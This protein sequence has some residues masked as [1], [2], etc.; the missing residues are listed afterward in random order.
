MTLVPPT[1]AAALAARYTIERELGR[2]GM[3]TVYLARD[4]KHDRPVALKLLSPDLAAVLG[5][6]RF[7]REIRMAARLQHPHILAVHDSGEAAGRLW[8]TMPFVDGESL[9]DRLRRERQLA[10][11]DAVR[12]GREA[13]LALD[14]AH[15]HGVVHRDIK[16]ENILLT[17]EGQVLIADFG[18]ARALQGEDETLTQTGLAVGTPTYMSPEQ[19]AG[20]RELDGRSDLY[21]L[22]CVVYEMLAGEPPHTGPSAQAILARRLT[23]P[24]RPLRSTRD[25]VPATVEAAVMRALAR[26]PA[27]RFPSTAEFARALETRDRV[28]PAGLGRRRLLVAAIAA[29]TVLAAGVTWLARHPA[30]P[31]STARA[32]IAIL[33]FAVR[34]NPALAYMGEG[35]VELL[36]TKLDGAGDLRAV[37][38]RALLSAVR[39]RS[40]ELAPDDGRAVARRFG[41]ERYVLGSVL[42]I[43]DSVRLSAGLY[44]AGGALQASAES[45]AREADIGRAVDE[46]A[47]L[48]LGRMSTT[49]ADRLESIGAVTTASFPALRAYLDGQQAF[50]AGQLDS[51]VAAFRRATELDT[52]FALA[53]YR[54]ATAATWNNQD[55]LWHEAMDRAVHHAKRLS[56]RDRALVEAQHSWRLGRLIESERRYHEIVSAYPDDQEAWFWLGDVRLHTNFL[57]GRGIAEAEPALRRALALDPRDWQARGHLEGLLRR[58]GRGAAA[59]SVDTPPD[60]T[61]PTFAFVRRDAPGA[62]GQREAIL[63]AAT[64][65]QLYILA[66]W[67]LQSGYDPATGLRIAT[68]L[69]EAGRPPPW[70][71]HGHLLLGCERL[72]G[73][74]WDAAD[75][76]FAA[77]ERLLPEDGLPYRAL[78]AV[79]SPVPVPDSTLRGLARRLRAW[80]PAPLRGH[81]DDKL[82]PTAAL[83][84]SRTLVRRFLIA[85]LDLRL[86]STKAAAEQAT[87]L[88]SIQDSDSAGSLAQDLAATINA[89]LAAGGNDADGVLRALET[90]RFIVFD[91]RFL[92]PLHSHGAARLLR[93]SALAEVGREDE[94]LG[95][96]DGLMRADVSVLDRQFL[97]AP[98]Y[99]VA[100][101]IY[102]RRGDRH[103]AL[104]A[105]GRFVELWREADPVVQEQVKAARDRMA[106][107]AAGPRTR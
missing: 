57:N 35:I 23:E 40:G 72:A 50:R 34:G 46:V 88:G 96:L 41:A 80:K 53:W 24:V 86:G 6:E 65:R 42:Q 30:P 4:L 19:G 44:Q 5:P 92:F 102:E 90:Q 17:A 54:L 63:Q 26:A 101:E 22:G 15:R 14:H 52:A 48:L 3:A 105:Y 37:D 69:T 62:A 64:P 1:L 36:S 87:A 79:S 51:A 91:Y 81:N 32:T 66:V 21:S 93:A 103:A 106:A 25:S 71:A 77:A 59:D 7:Q 11:E 9:R 68:M 74:R 94:A 75:T 49:P 33:P 16:P 55:S 38:P 89:S 83:D 47:R 45:V 58:I 56:A 61:S 78:F 43:G 97:R 85:L 12:I 29:A 13:A 8:F 82:S 104:E 100:G 84:G 98:A 10:V 2:G 60:T 107:L 99:R 95:W 18:V 70:R 73:G 39:G 27:D 67:L 28:A 76:E 31:A 20:E